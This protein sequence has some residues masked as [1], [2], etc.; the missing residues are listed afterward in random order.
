MYLKDAKDDDEVALDF[1]VALGADLSKPMKID[2][3]VAAPDESSARQI[4]SAAIGLG[5][6]TDIQFDDDDSDLEDGDSFAWTCE[7]TKD[8]TPSKS[9]LVALQLQLDRIARPFGGYAD[10]WGTFGNVKTGDEMTE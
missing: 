1:V 10:G 3:H 2:F 8:M 6:H 5:F 4:A 7:C 9:E